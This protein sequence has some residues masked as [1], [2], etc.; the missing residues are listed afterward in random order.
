MFPL[1]A[2][3]ALATACEDEN[4]VWN[5]PALESSVEDFSQYTGEIIRIGIETTLPNASAT[6]EAST[7]ALKED[8]GVFIPKCWE[9][10]QY[11]SP[12]AIKRLARLPTRPSPTHA[13]N[14]TMES[15]NWFAIARVCN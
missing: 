9:Q 6:P 1:L 13:S 11:I 10:S 15:I 3:L 4:E 12:C 2:L 7:R 5:E 8:N 14:S